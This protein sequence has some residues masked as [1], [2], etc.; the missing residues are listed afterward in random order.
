MERNLSKASTTSDLASNTSAQRNHDY[1]PLVRLF[2][3]NSPQQTSDLLA[4]PGSLA[5]PPTNLS[6]TTYFNPST[7]MSAT[8]TVSPSLQPS[9]TPMINYGVSSSTPIPP[10]STTSQQW[11]D[12]LQTIKPLGTK[13]SPA[14]HDLDNSPSSS[15]SFLSTSPLS[16]STER[17]HMTPLSSTYLRPSLSLDEQAAATPPSSSKLIPGISHSRSPT[18]FAVSNKLIPLTRP[19][20]PDDDV[21]SASSQSMSRT[22]SYSDQRQNH[23]LSQDPTTLSITSPNGHHQELRPPIPSLASSIPAIS[24]QIGRH[25]STASSSSSSS[26]SNHLARRVRSATTLRRSEE[27]TVP[28][29]ALVT[30]KQQ[31]Y[32]QQQSQQQKVSKQLNPSSPT[33]ITSDNK[34]HADHRRSISA[35]NVAKCKDVMQQKGL[36]EQLDNHLSQKY[37]NKQALNENGKYTATSP[38][39]PL[40]L[41]PTQQEIPSTTIKPLDLDGVNTTSTICDELYM[42]FSDLN[43]WLDRLDMAVNQ[44]TFS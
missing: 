13:N 10:P 5:N 11:V 39:G 15:G 21:T 24:A 30:N 19:S 18:Q 3:N 28:L 9:P 41:S 27:D 34:K 14:A 29:K 20:S 43:G 25:N 12:Q 26:S 40:K 7:S 6:P 4:P 36:T 17:T 33:H 38:Q 31:L 22:R 32:H 2:E 37:G 16:S 1:H 42:A 23:V 8:P 44:Q 35:D